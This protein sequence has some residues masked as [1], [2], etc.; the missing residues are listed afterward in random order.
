MLA[1]TL[2]PGFVCILAALIAL[3]SPRMVRPALIVGAALAALWLLV[4]ANPIA[5]FLSPVWT[6]P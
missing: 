3:A 6:P 4:L 2:N 5:Y 1:I